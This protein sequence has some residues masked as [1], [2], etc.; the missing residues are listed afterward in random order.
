MRILFDKNLMIP[1]RTRETLSWHLRYSLLRR[2]LWILTASHGS[3]LVA[4]AI[5]DQCDNP[6]TSLK[7]VRVVDFQTLR[8][9]EFAQT[10]IME[11]MK[12][13]SIYWNRSAPR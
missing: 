4:C 10:N 6:A 12:P 3:K 8:G 7:R 9:Y 2:A 1:V 11:R 5:F 13:A